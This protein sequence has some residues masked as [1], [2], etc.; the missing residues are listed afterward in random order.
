MLN[1]ANAVSGLNASN[2]T[3]GDVQFTNTGALG[4]TAQTTGGNVTIGN[5]GTLSSTGAIT[6]TGGNVTLTSTGDMSI[7]HAVTGGSGVDLNVTG[8]DKF[9]NHTAGTISTTNSAI[10][11]V[12][13]KMALS[14]GTVNAGNATITLRPNAAAGKIDIGSVTDLAAG[15]LELSSAELATLVTS[16][17]VVIGDAVNTGAV[18]VSA[19]T[20]IG[21]GAN[22]FNIVNNT[23]DITLNAT[24]TS[25]I[26]TNITSAGSN[27]I[28]GPAGA[29][30]AGARD[31][32]LSALAGMID[33][34]SPLGGFTN[35]TANNL[36]M[37][38]ANGMGA[39]NFI[40]TIV[41]N[42]TV[43]NTTAGNVQIF[44]SGAV[45]IGGVDNGTPGV[46]TPGDFSLYATGDVTQTGS[47]HTQV[48]NVTTFN[49]AGAAINLPMYTAGNALVSNHSSSFNL[50][51]CLA[52]P[53]GCPP[54]GNPPGTGASFAAGAITYN[55]FG[56][57]GV[58]GVGTISSFTTF[59]G[60]NFNFG[61]G[62]FAAQNVGI[63]ASGNITFNGFTGLGDAAINGGVAGGSIAFISGGNITFD[64]SP[65]AGSFGTA[66][67]RFNHDLIFKAGGDVSIVSNV[68]L[69]ANNFTA[70][71]NQSFVTPNQV[72]VA[73]GNGAVALVGGTVDVLGVGGTINLLGDTV[74][75]GGTLLSAETVTLNASN[76]I[77]NVG[78]L[79]LLAQN[80]SGVTGAGAISLNNTSNNPV[81]VTN[82]ASGNGNIDYL[83]TG[84]GSVTFGTVS[85]TAG[86]VSLNN[87]SGDLT[88]ATSVI[89]SGNNVTLIGDHVTL[90][91][92][93][94]AGGTALING[95]TDINGSGLVK[96]QTVKLFSNNGVGNTTEVD[97]STGLLYIDAGAGNIDVA[98]DF[99]SAVAINT[100]RTTN[101]NITFIQSGG[102]ALNFLNPVG[103]G[104]NVTITNKGNDLTIDRALTAGGNV[105][106]T[107]A[108]QLTISQQVTGGTGVLLKT[109]GA[110]D[111]LINSDVT[112]TTGLLEADSANNLTIGTGN[113]TTAGDVKLSAGAL[114]EET[115]TGIV[116]GALLATSSV[117]GTKLN[118]ANVVT[119][120]NGSN[121]KSGNIE[122]THDG[123]SLSITG[124]DQKGGG[125][126][127]IVTS[128]DLSADGALTVADSGRLDL[129]AAA[130]KI[131][132]GDI[133][134]ITTDF[135]VTTS[136]SGTLLDGVN[137]VAQYAA[138]NTDSGDI[139]LNNATDLLTLD[140]IL[141]SGAGNVTIRNI[142][143]DPLLKGRLDISGDGVD[144][145][146][147]NVNFTTTGNITQSGGVK[148]KILNVTTLNDAGA[149]IVLGSVKNHTDEVNLYSCMTAG[150]GQ[151]VATKY[152]TGDILY[153][154]SG[155]TN[156]RQVG[157]RGGFAGYAA[158]ALNFTA[159][160]FSA[161]D[162]LLEGQDVTFSNFAGLA[163]SQ[164]GAGGFLKIV[165]GRDIVYDGV[166]LGGLIGGAGNAFQHDLS[167]I[168]GR[169]IKLGSGM[170]TGTGLF[171][172]AAGQDVKTKYQD[173]KAAGFKDASAGTV[174]MY[175]NNQISSLGN[176][177]ISGR[178]FVMLGG[179]NTA[180]ADAPPGLNGVP[181]YVNSN[182]QSGVGQELIAAGAI[183]L[184]LT[185][186][187]TIQAGTASAISGSGAAIS[188]NA[189]NIGSADSR[190]KSLNVLG[191]TSAL[192][193]AG[194]R[195]ADASVNALTDL[196]VYAGDITLTGGTV[197]GAAAAA[198]Q[199]TASAN[200]M[201]NGKNLVI[202]TTGDLVL[203]G[204][205]VAA[206]VLAPL[207]PLSPF[208]SA[209]ASALI[210][211]TNAKT[212]NIGGSL[213]MTGGDTTLSVP[214]SRVHAQ[215]V[216][217]PGTLTIKTGGDIVL[218]G[219][220]GGSTEAGILGTDAFTFI[221]GGSTGLRLVGGAGS[222]LFD[223]T[224]A[225]LDGSG[226]PITLIFTG[227]GTFKII[228]DV[229]LGDAF[230]QSAAGLN[231]D[232]LANFSISSID[233]TKTKRSDGFYDDKSVEIRVRN[234]ITESRV[235]R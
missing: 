161:R 62:T 80:I 137:K 19:A 86:T 29:I 191:G 67:A 126:A 35:V 95:A 42:V 55:D 9:I 118:N 105:T 125:D 197:G 183:N 28:F 52:L 68:Y 60:G 221:I 235:C 70:L 122:F 74:N 204:G 129:Q 85:T 24:L 104:G 154:D 199:V 59:S 90:D 64:S 187:V 186:D 224:N 193:A 172:I 89:S 226:F 18:T 92:T 222:G 101:G 15:T 116:S 208:S 171:S 184:L 94:T 88:V 156:I 21:A 43:H 97:T 138:T 51:T 27:V 192:T 117:G 143:A 100:L 39:T 219:D 119:G 3:A 181:P 34:G 124:I 230:V 203:Q 134:V 93:T 190:V 149:N 1:A 217:D 200:A 146:T 232:Q 173:V 201:L 214:L 44:N 177:D 147:G 182:V 144:A 56:G 84:T 215:A 234:V 158:G 141:Q 115:G 157:T 195:L 180:A 213:L 233:R 91:G 225:R 81:T 69:G 121:S 133:S 87:S 164:I 229:T 169:D 152:A 132:Q 131:M 202:D 72:V 165:A 46:Q 135:L 2:S 166:A 63:E 76:G 50:F 112:T 8:V 107:A 175:G 170:Y 31:V 96:G 77:G 210:M 38:A 209:G 231:L 13:D 16:G 218:T 227:G 194:N 189:I 211:A 106:L 167:L 73:S 57:S 212:L 54:S 108:G 163:N 99:S 82:L 11:L 120:F 30:N 220:S 22:S 150:C 206:N 102:G 10:N 196:N 14:G 75:G 78:T 17:S 168:A 36:T 216:I 228:G 83:Q 123:K 26:D 127:I 176:I 178:N 4:V 7:G 110:G 142:V 148:G 159:D 205:T 155:D 162:A 20:N 25:A 37:S 32:A 111:I 145:G 103:G 79:N 48:L 185:G 6:S 113:L 66:G 23:G 5:T 12:A 130:G 151:G 45:A 71:A 109:I 140:G 136:K 41:N 153:A 179:R 139:R 198:D 58:T 174:S 160:V 114:I 40:E 98:N 188:A 128:G 61:P 223:A 47:L 207:N 65:A 33:G 49:N 53:I